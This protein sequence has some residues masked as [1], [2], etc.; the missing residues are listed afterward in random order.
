MWL[1]DDTL[2]RV[3]DAVAL[4]SPERYRL[5]RQ[6][7]RG[8][9][10]IVYLAE[11]TELGR[12]V[13]LKVLHSQGN[14][15]RLL[16]EA[17]TL[18]SLEHPG[19]I[20]VHDSGTLADGR[21]FYVMKRVDGKRFDYYVR[22]AGLAEALRMFQKVCEAV[23]FAHSRGVLHCDL[24]PQNIMVGSF[25][26]VLVMDWGM[27]GAGT[28]GYMSPEQA[29]GDAALDLRT[30]V[31]A[32]GRLLSGLSVPRALAAVAAKASA[33]DACDR[34]QSVAEL[35]GEITRYVEGQPVAAHRETLGERAARIFSRHRI[36]IL[37]VAAYLAMRVLFFVAKGG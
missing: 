11:D 14:S 33:E 4:P 3:R 24:K 34:Y 37:V 22:G 8:G 16:H 18:A 20:P 12:E 13:A 25:G 1:S 9:M 17:R 26:E 29:R 27:A 36:A 23:A 6:L 10:G 30:D 35:S 2:R 32:L 5:L 15:E 28:P 21:V 31:Y 19:I 7:G